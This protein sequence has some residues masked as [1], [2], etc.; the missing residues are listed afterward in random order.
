MLVF[1]QLALQKRPAASAP[2]CGWTEN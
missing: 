2:L 1:Q